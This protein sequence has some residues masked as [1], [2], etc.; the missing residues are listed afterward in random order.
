M[1]FRRAKNKNKIVIFF[2]KKPKNR[3][4]GPHG[5]MN[6]TPTFKKTIIENFEKKS[7]DK[8]FVCQS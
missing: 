1:G 8:M 4:F 6:F 3:T 5:L 2:K 7:R